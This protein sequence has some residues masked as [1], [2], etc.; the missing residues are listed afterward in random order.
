MA[1]LWDCATPRGASK[2]SCA[3]RR[4]AIA[5]CCSHARARP[6]CA[7]RAAG[8]CT[9]RVALPRGAPG[10]FAGRGRMHFYVFLQQTVVALAPPRQSSNF[11]SIPR[12]W[13]VPTPMRG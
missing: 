5:A 9:R 10:D 4:M 12:V 3:L 1:A 6:N 7:A 2:Q 13:S 11:C 8:S